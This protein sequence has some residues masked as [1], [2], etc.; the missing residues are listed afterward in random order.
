MRYDA[1]QKIIYEP[2][3]LVTFSNSGALQGELSS[4]NSRFDL[5]GEI[6]TTFGFESG[7]GV[8]MIV[9]NGGKAFVQVL[10]NGKL[11]TCH[12]NNIKLI[13]ER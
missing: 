1:N 9:I 5:R 13:S 3:D 6:I 8:I 4:I 7:D 12:A 11:G 10:C 2:G